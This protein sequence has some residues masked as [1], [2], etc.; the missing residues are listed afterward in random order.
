MYVFPQIR[1]SAKA[2]EAAKEQKMTPDSYYALAMLE[3]TGVCV[4]PGS[5]FG[6]EPN[7]YHFRSTFLPEEHLFEKFCGALEKF[8]KEFM[9]KHRA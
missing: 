8:H 2:I 7:T 9:D 5:G 6:Q 1:L 4:I 3:A